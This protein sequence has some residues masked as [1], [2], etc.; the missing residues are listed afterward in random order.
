[1]DINQKTGVFG[2]GNFDTKR[3]LYDQS[4]YILNLDLSYD[5]PRLGTSASI[6]YNTAGPR[7]AVASLNTADIYEQPTPALDFILSQRIGRHASVKFVAKNLLNPIVD[8]TYGKDSDLLF[9]SFR[10]GMTFGLS[11]GYEF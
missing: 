2:K 8:R 5:N 1:M 4:P 11:L 9:S 3:S 7:I 10:K 6:V